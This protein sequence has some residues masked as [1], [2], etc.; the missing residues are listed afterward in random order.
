[1]FV[2]QSAFSLSAGGPAL[3]R[4]KGPAS[5]ALASPTPSAPT[6]P[7]S[8]TAL[9]PPVHGTLG[10]QQ[11]LGETK[12]AEAEKTHVG[13]PAVPEQHMPQENFPALPEARTRGGPGGPIVLSMP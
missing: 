10:K 13:K 4:P 6:P 8:P 3:P 7:H 11:A 2:L 5:P 9:A 1:M 12:P